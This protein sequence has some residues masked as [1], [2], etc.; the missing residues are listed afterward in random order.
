[1]FTIFLNSD[2]IN[3]GGNMHI[4]KDILACNEWGVLNII[5]L[6]NLLA[7]MIKIGV[8]IVL[9]IVC[10]IDLAKMMTGKEEA[11]SRIT[12]KNIREIY[13]SYSSIFSI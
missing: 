13:G 11:Y 7:N 3:I 9:I 1:M 2:N 4:L 5:Y 12:K 8:P 10:I 6:D